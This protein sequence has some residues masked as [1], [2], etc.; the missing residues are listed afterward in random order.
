MSKTGYLIIAI[1]IIVGLVFLFF[2][3]YIKQ[4]RLKMPEGYQDI[5]PEESKCQGC[6]ELGCP[7]YARFHK[8]DN[9]G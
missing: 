2:F 7:F 9:D 6:A 8:E 3:T 1:A 5:H 4:R